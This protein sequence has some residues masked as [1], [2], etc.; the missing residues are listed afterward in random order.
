MRLED[1]VLDDASGVHVSSAEVRQIDYSD[2]AERYLKKVLTSVND[3]GLLSSQ[4]RSKI[5]YWDWAILY[6]LSPYRATILDCFDFP[7]NDA[8]VL[9]LGAGCG[10]VTRWLGEHF[11]DTY[12]VEGSFQRACISRLRCRDLPGV[13]V[14]AANFF[15]LELEK[16]FDIVTLIGVLEYSP[17]YHPVYR[18]NPYKAAL[19]TLQFAYNAIKDQGILLLAI[20]NKLGLK[21]FSGAREDHSGKFFDSIHGYPDAGTPVT[22][23]AAELDSLLRSAGFTSVDFYLP[24]PDYKLAKTII[25]AQ[26]LSTFHHYLYNW[27][28]T[29]FPDRVEP[30]RML[31]F[32]ESLALRE[33]MKARLLKDLSNSFLLVAH[34]GKKDEN[35]KKFNLSADGWIVKHY[36]LDRYQAFCK[37]V[38]LLKTVSGSLKVDK[39]MAFNKS[40]EKDIQHTAFIHAIEPEKYYAGDLLLLSVFEMLASQ[41]FDSMFQPLLEKLNGFL[42]N[43]F[44]SG[45]SDEAGIPFL[46]GE[47]LDVTLWNIIVEEGTGEWIIF[48][49]EWTFNG[50]LPV[51]L[52]IW[53]N[54]HYL[55]DLYGNYFEK[56][57]FRRPVAELVCGWIQKLYPAFNEERY[58]LSMQFEE[59]LQNYVNQGTSDIET[60]HIIEKLCRISD[61]SDRP[62]LDCI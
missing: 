28:E 51:D 17:V 34:K 39:C 41:K 61:R 20:E 57:Y 8:K 7:N 48:D 2:G 24:F 40:S 5:D 55:F 46:S 11:K 47:S 31:F 35:C 14:Y 18:K 52:V 4:I 27:I 13:K 16:Q 53:R 1:F 43:R 29:P 44:S 50:L 15:D 62:G 30:Q 19:S 60:Y 32:N 42:I 25:N 38:S 23:S 21:Y 37:K 56:S 45:E 54:V 9:E 33:I 10:G 12:A 36:T 22:F 58:N 26:A 3:L 6:H 49:R 59:S